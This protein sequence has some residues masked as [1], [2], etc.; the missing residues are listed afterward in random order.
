M[1][2]VL[3]Y[4]YQMAREDQI[5]IH[6]WIGKSPLIDFLETLSGLINKKQMRKYEEKM[7]INQ[8]HGVVRKIT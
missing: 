4:K 1:K 8:K 5:Y 7:T 3:R 6:T 2:K